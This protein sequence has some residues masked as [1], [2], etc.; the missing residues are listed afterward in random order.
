MRRKAGE[1]DCAWASWQGTFVDIE[2]AFSS[3]CVG[4]SRMLT[5]ALKKKDSIKTVQCTAYTGYC[6]DRRIWQRGW[7]KNDD[8][9][10]WIYFNITM[11][12]LEQA[13]PAD[14]WNKL[15]K[16]YWLDCLSI[17]SIFFLNLQS[18]AGIFCLGMSHRYAQA[19]NP[20]FAEFAILGLQDVRFVFIGEDFECFRN[21]AASRRAD[22]THTANFAHVD[23][24]WLFGVLN[25]NEN[26]LESW[27]RNPYVEYTQRTLFRCPLGDVPF[28]DRTSW[29]P[30]V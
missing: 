13:A 21:V 27:I 11:C 19:L 1:W 17:E 18:T 26:E 6:I 9:P 2:A 5:N 12:D 22:R 16:R 30:K 24:L 23:W 15:N 7:E 10:N 3:S 20:L 4:Q 25:G 8:E 28:H 14:G 29:R